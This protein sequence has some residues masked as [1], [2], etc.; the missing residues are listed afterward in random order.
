MQNLSSVGSFGF[1]IV[2][3]IFSF[4]TFNFVWADTTE[5]QDFIYL[6][7]LYYDTGQLV[8][9][10]DA[11]F[12]YDV[13]P[14]TFVPETLDT[15]F[16]YKGEVINLKGEVA[17]TFQFDPKQGNPSFLKGT[18]LVKAP[19]LPDGQKAIFYNSQGQSL[20][21]V[22]VSESSFC[23]DDGACNSDVGEDTKTCP[24]D[25]RQVLP[26]PTTSTEPS[27]GD[28]RSGVLKILTYLIIGLGL[29][30]GGWYVGSAIWRRWKKKKE[31]NFPI[32]PAP[33]S[34][35]PPLNPTS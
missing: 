1:L 13:L 27:V 9:D 2:I 11:Q 20:L 4:L 6:F 35:A 23:N 14:E 34:V 19:Y 15:Q 28:G 29:A 7:H 26:V 33:P 12:K 31:S 25:C 32:P 3:F 21:T 22:F 10:R 18:L 30:G 17:E 24:S 16:P 5:S 8:A